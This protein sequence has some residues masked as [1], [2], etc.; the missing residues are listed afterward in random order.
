M[1][2]TRIALLALGALSCANAAAAALETIA[3]RSGDRRTGR[4][5][6]VERLCPAYAQRWPT[7]V[8]CVEFAR[9][10][11]GVPAWTLPMGEED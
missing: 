11:E 1:N 9:T 10:P 2:R 8:R 6:E 4:Y 3:E 7:Q 5:E